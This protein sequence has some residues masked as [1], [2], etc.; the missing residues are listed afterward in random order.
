MPCGPQSGTPVPSSGDCPDGIAGCGIGLKKFEPD[1]CPTGN[2]NIYTVPVINTGHTAHGEG[3]YTYPQWTRQSSWSYV[4]T[5]GTIT[6]DNQ[7]I[8]THSAVKFEEYDVGD[9]WADPKP[10]RIGFAL[11]GFEMYVMRHY[12]ANGKEQS[13]GFFPM[14]PTKTTTAPNGS[15]RHKNTI[16]LFSCPDGPRFCKMWAILNSADWPGASCNEQWIE[17]S[18]RLKAESACIYAYNGISCVENDP[19]MWQVVYGVGRVSNYQFDHGRYYTIP[20]EEMFPIVEASHGMENHGVINSGSRIHLHT[21]EHMKYYFSTCN[22]MEHCY[23]SPQYSGII[24]NSCKGGSWDTP[25]EDGSNSWNNIVPWNSLS[26]VAEHDGFD[27]YDKCSTGGPGAANNPRGDVYDICKGN[28]V[29]T[30]CC[31]I[32]GPLIESVSPDILYHCGGCDITVEVGPDCG[33]YVW[34]V[35][36]GSEWVGG[37]DTDGSRCTFSLLDDLER[38]DLDEATYFV[39][40]RAVD[41]RTTLYVDYRFQILVPP[42]AGEEFTRKICM[43]GPVFRGAAIKTYKDK[44]P[45][46]CRAINQLILTQGAN[47]PCML[48]LMDVDDDALYYQGL[49]WPNNECEDPGPRNAFKHAYANCMMACKCGEST[50]QLL[51]DAHEEYSVEDK[52]VCLQSSMDMNNNEIGRSLIWNEENEDCSCVSLVVAEM[53]SDNGL[54]RWSNIGPNWINTP[55]PPCLNWEHGFTPNEQCY[56]VLFNLTQ[57]PYPPPIATATPSP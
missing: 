34:T 24:C 45:R 56:P 21:E 25:N 40:V 14:G 4:N 44:T 51:S 38:P 2:T 18:Y 37:L 7:V 22:C 27:V 19:M 26:E 11:A 50:A 32:G 52:Q 28:A 57:T 6:S 8:G 42:P 48:A 29:G 5:T 17:I 41:T 31:G 16:R 46:E 49:L 43:V 10:S 39:T 36:E 13:A 9:N 33:T 15:K 12:L 47:I 20:P 53:L 23:G 3:T 35:I 1:V 54:V 55:G 30:P